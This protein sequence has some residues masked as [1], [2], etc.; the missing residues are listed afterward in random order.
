M[1]TQRILVLAGAFVAA[2]IVA[3]LVSH[4][5][6]GG[7]PPPVKAEPPPPPKV[8]TSEV[9]VAAA[10]LAPGMQLTDASVKW[11]EW[12]KSSVDSSFIT[13]DANPDVDK[14]VAGAVVRAPLVS[15]EPLST[16]KIVQHAEGAGFMAA[17]VTPGMRAVSIPVTTESGAGG[18]ILPNDRVDVV[19]T[20]QVSDS[21]RRFRAHTILS[22]VRVLAMDQ[23]FENKDEKT[24]LAKTATL[25]LSPV[26]AEMV[27]RAQASG[28]LALSLR[29]L[30]DGTAATQSLASASQDNRITEGVVSVIRYG[31]ERPSVFGQKE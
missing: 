22:N 10:D 19:A 16:S 26:Q 8:A 2:I 14:V 5:L 12:P 13:H 18:F 6:G 21:P 27:E 30:G 25:E 23:T 24:V 1:N 17:M 11:Q 4:L 7:G 31:I 15:G 28:T 9:L 3:F 29:A 20:V